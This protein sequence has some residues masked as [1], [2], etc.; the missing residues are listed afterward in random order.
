MLIASVPHQNRPAIRTAAAPQDYYAF[1]QLCRTYVDWCRG[2]YADMPWFV[3]ALFG[4]Q[5]LEDELQA[6]T[7]RYDRPEGRAVI[8]TMS[9]AAVACGAI[10][11]MS[12]TV[13]EL[14]RVFVR[15]EARGAG[16]GRRLTTTLIA[17][18]VADGF[19]TMRLDT[20]D[21]LTEAIAMYDSMGFTRIA[22][23]RRYPERL[24]PHL[25][26]ME[27]AL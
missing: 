27:K 1:G 10:H 17:A 16:L 8:A 5:S 2:R 24:M 7:T 21:R 18:A 13:C 14:K 22:P 6:L 20:A 19:T 4:G 11:R 3:E 26:F 12:D 23:Y 9:G 25:V 15:E